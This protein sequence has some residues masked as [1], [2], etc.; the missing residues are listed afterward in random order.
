MWL[1]RRENEG[2]RT[3]SSAKKGQCLDGRETQ[4]GAVGICRLSII[5]N[6]K[7]HLTW[8]HK[9]LAH[10]GHALNPTLLLHNFFFEG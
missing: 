1:G 4:T 9:G 2:Q 5:L 8:M 3:L 10:V 6:Q 7:W